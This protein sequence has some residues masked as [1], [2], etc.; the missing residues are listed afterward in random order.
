[1]DD[2]CE[3]THKHHS[4]GSKSNSLSKDNPLQRSG[5][6]EF[7]MPGVFEVRQKSSDLAP[8]SQATENESVFRSYLAQSRFSNILQIKTAAAGLNSGRT[9]YISTRSCPD[10]A[11]CRQSLVTQL[12]AQAR[13]ARRKA[14]AKSRFQRSQD[15]VKAVQSS[16]L[17]QLCMA[18]LIMAVRAPSPRR[19][20]KRIRSIQADDGDNN[21]SDVASRLHSP[22]FRAGVLIPPTPHPLLQKI[23]RTAARYC[24]LSK[25]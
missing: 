24:C 5:I 8:N 25:G 4:L 1:M 3:T 18:T 14:E 6:S 7:V 21:M 2:E 12:S 20:G 23:A 22:K 17:F 9:Y 13:I 11:E 19:H 16:R 10:A 15:N